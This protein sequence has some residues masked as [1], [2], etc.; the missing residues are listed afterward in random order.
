MFTHK[1][2]FTISI[3]N[4]MLTSLRSKLELATFPDE[5]DDADWNYG[6]P[7]AHIIRLVAR[8]KGGYD[9]RK[10][11]KELNEELP[12]FT[13]DIDVD[14]FGTLNIHYVHQK[15]EAVGSV[16]LL[17]VHGWPGS[18]LEVRKILPLLT[19]GSPQHPNFH[20]V[21]LSLPGFG[22]SDAPRK[23]GFSSVQY[24]EVAN[25]LMLAL[26]Y[27]EYGGDWGFWVTRKIANL[28]GGMNS[29]AWHTNFPIGEP[30]RLTSNPF[31]FISHLLT[32]YTGAEKAGLAR[33]TW[34]RTQGRGYFALQS[35]QPQTLGYALAD[36]PVALLAWIS[37]KLVLWSDDYGWD[38]DEV[39]TWISTY[40]FS[41][42]GPAASLRIY[43][44]VTQ[45]NERTFA[46]QAPNIP[47]GISYFPKELF[48]P[49]RAWTRGSG[50]VVFESE[51]EDGGHFAAYEKPRELVDDIRKMFQKGG[52][53][54][55][56]VSGSTG[57]D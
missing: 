39:L 25:K 20:V 7:M 31:A 32:P 35:T 4:E 51:H 9:W 56:L 19:R 8:W 5:L 30:P 14:D 10:Y 43:F 41:R 28:Y 46:G 23:Q 42:A 36:S 48:L 54:Y 55:G 22:F 11:E 24:A 6:V 34:F 17:F 2:P 26:G 3:S 57:Y 1:N 37:E 29:K 40:W 12:M 47:M 52:P 50:R 15:G 13:K 18:F 38:D 21:A 27:T 33:T 44:E 53:A 45:N 16:P 49:P